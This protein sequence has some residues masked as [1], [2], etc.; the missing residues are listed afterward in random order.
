MQI[1]KTNAFKRSAK[2]LHNNQAISLEKSI[3]KIR[4]NPNIGENKK[5]DCLGV[6]VYK[7]HM[8]GQLTLIA[9]KYYESKKEIILLDVGTHE[10]FYRNLKK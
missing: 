9:Y 6:K 4:V 2:R 3:E 1:N 10:N 8:I 5:G 7:F